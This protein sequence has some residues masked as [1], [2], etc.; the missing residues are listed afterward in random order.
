MYTAWIDKNRKD[1]SMDE[2]TN[3]HLVSILNHVYK[4]GGWDSF[5]RVEAMERLYDESLNRKLNFHIGKFTYLQEIRQREKERIQ[6][7]RELIFKDFD[8]MN[9]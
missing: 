2:I 6:F 5:V 8:W 3:S 7:E 4:G 1:Y 9:D